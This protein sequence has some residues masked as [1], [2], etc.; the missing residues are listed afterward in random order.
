MARRLR[1]NRVDGWY[2][3]F[4]RGIER[5]SIFLDNAD[6]EH[7]T[8]LLGEAKAR[9]R[10]VI[11]A[12]SLMANHW[13][14]VVQTPEAN[15][16]AAMQWLHLSHAAWFNARHSRVGP[17]WQGRFRAVP[18]EDGAWAYEVSLYVHMNPVCTGEFGM[19]KR[20]KK[21]EALG[22]TMP[23]AEQ[24]TRRVRELREYR[25]SS[26]RIYGGY[27]KGPEWL[28]SA[29]LLARA[30]R[31]TRRAQTAYRR[32]IK[33]RL[34]HGVAES[35]E[36]RLRD[37]IAIGGEG[38]VRKIRAL[39][40]GG[41]R[42]TSGKRELRRWRTPGEIMGEVERIRGE[43][44][45]ELVERRGDPAR[46]LAMWTLRHYGGLTLRQIGEQFGGMD[47]A[48]VSIAIKRFETKAA[49]GK[50]LRAQMKQMTEMLNVE[51]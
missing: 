24:V 33:D 12:Y 49:G 18:I 42:E 17:L 13:H 27:A 29:V 39:A 1:S 45:N 36:E 4:H 40:Q 23:R 19:G 30:D 8:E 31:D 5:R 41:N 14:G 11:H 20:D 7:F 2:H 26:Y 25:W 28:E 43:A 48:A 37:A 16:S 32:D 38:F 46:A 34:R 44:W 50:A 6:R 15:L 35:K 3:V 21:T 10:L 51:T 22:L 47:Y 9:Y